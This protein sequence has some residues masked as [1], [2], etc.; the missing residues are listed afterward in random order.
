MKI[1]PKEMIPGELYNIRFSN[2]L[3]EDKYGVMFLNLFIVYD[4]YDSTGM[5]LSFLYKK[6]IAKYFHITSKNNAFK[7]DSK[8]YFERFD[9][10]KKEEI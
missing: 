10:E 4:E 9:F 3:V 5:F 1:D 6:D 7:G 2:E 8:K